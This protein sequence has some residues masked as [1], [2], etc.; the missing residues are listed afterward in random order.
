MATLK[1]QI[2]ETEQEIADLTERMETARGDVVA[3]VGRFA[4][5][6]WPAEAKRALH[7]DAERAAELEG[8]CLGFLKADVDTLADGAGE[9]AEEVLDDPGLWPHLGNPQSRPWREEPAGRAL[10]PALRRLLARVLPIL[11]RYRLRFDDRNGRPITDRYPQAV[12]VPGDLADAARTYFDLAAE[13][14]AADAK[15]EALRRRTG[16]AAVDAVWKKA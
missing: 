4:A 14:R 12:E 3:A 11:I 10:D 13:L 7:L 1:Q 16:A 15:L 8:D 5:D 2:G 6:W 9:A